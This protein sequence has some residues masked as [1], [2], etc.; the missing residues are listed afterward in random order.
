MRFSVLASSSKANC[1]F[2]EAGDTRLLLDC[3]ISCRQVCVR[4]ESIG[5]DPATIQAILVTH[6]HSDH[7]KGCSV[8]SRKFHVPVHATAGT[9]RF[10]K[11]VYRI[12]KFASDDQFAIGEIHVEP[13]EIVHDAT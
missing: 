6:E 5:V 3:G 4:L 9:A 8:F 12:N 2:I 13:F 7:I 11:D 10:I 1:T